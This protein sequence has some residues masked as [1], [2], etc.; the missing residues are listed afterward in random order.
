[1]DPET[2]EPSE[3][4]P[5]ARV[6]IADG[7]DTYRDIARVVLER[8]GYEVHGATAGREL[9]AAMRGRST[10]L[11]ITEFVLPDMTLDELLAGI[12][13]RRGTHKLPVLVVTA[14][15]DPESQV[16]AMDGGVDGWLAKPY[17]TK[18]LLA[19]V[20]SLVRMKRL[21]DETENFESVLASLSSAVEAKDPYTR[22]HSERVSALGT[23]VAVE[24]G[25]DGLQQVLLRRAGLVH[26]IGKLVVDLSFINKPGKLEEAEWAVMKTHPEAGARIC[27]PLRSALPLIPLVRHHH[28]KLNG[29]GYPDG[30]VEDQIP[31]EVRVISVA[32]VYDA[33]TTSR[34]YRSALTHA[35]A[36]DIL[37]REVDE[38]CWDPEVVDVVDEIGAEA[39]GGGD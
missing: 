11:V 7:D 16:R 36:M 19:H 2:F 1:M 10:D 34:P 39:Y 18:V 17:E 23:L 4:Q 30:L 20:R 27:A 12:E 24:L 6:L 15:F 33:L 29:G 13:E 26:D 37:R 31:P 8:E 9:L 28:E 25:M 14:R 21:D 32:D 22:G 3:L 35:Q 5:P 38:G